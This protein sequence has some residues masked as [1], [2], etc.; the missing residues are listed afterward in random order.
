MLEGKEPSLDSGS[1][2]AEHTGVAGDRHGIA[3]EKQEPGAAHI[4]AILMI[5]W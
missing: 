3:A 2:G 5:L 4:W 1:N